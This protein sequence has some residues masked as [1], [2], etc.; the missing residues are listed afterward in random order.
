MNESAVLVERV[1]D[2]FRLTDVADDT[3]SRPR[4]PRETLQ[5]R[6]DKELELAHQQID[7]AMAQVRALE[8]RLERADHHV[9]KLVDALARCIEG[10]AA[11]RE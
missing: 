10:R 4:R 6:H 8:Q 7:D 11:P 5:E 9:T 2:K 3:E 1:G